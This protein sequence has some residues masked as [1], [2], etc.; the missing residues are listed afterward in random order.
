MDGL[1]AAASVIAV[2]QISGQ[3]SSLCRAYYLEVKDARNEIQRLREEV[4][5]LEDVLTKVMD[6]AD[7]PTATEVEVLKLVN[8]TEGPVQQCQAFL[9][10]L[11]AQLKK[12]QGSDTMK[13]FGLRALK[14]PFS[15]KDVKACLETIARHKATFTLAIALDD[16][17]LSRAIKADITKL[18]NDLLQ[19]Q[20]EQTTLIENGRQQSAEL[21]VDLLQLQ[22]GHDALLLDERRQKIHQWLSA[23]NPSSNHHAARKKQQATTG[24]W[25]VDDNQFAAWRDGAHSFLWLHGIRH[26]LW[27]DY[28]MAS[29][30]CS[31]IIQNVII[32][33]QSD[34]ALAIGF[35]YFDF[36]DVEK[37]KP[38]NLIRSLIT[39]LSLHSRNNPAHLETLYSKCQ[40][41][42][43]RPSVDSLMSTLKQMLGDFR[44][45]FVIIDA[46]DECKRWEELTDIV[47]SIVGWKIE[48]LHL[49]VTSRRERELMDAFD[50]LV[51][52]QIA[53]EDETVDVDIQTYV[54]HKLANDTKLGKWPAELKMEIESTLTNGAHGMFR[55]VVCQ[56]DELRKC[57]KPAV[58]RNALKSLPRTLDDTYAR[59]LCNIDEQY[60]EDAFKILQWLACS[61][62]PLTI[63]EVA[64][65]L[66]VNTEGYPRVDPDHRLRD[67][68]DVLIICSSLVTIVASTA[69]DRYGSK[70]PQKRQELRL[71]HFSVKEYLVSDRIQAGPA[72]R[73]KIT[74]IAD[75]YIAQTCLAYLL[76]FNEPNVQIP[77]YIDDPYFP[78]GEY[79]SEDA[80]YPLALYATLYWTQHAQ[81]A[82]CDQEVNAV[83]QLCM[84]LLSGRHAYLNSTRFFGA[85]WPRTFPTELDLTPSNV[86]ISSIRFA[87][88]SGL[89]VPVRQLLTENTVDINAEIA[90]HGTALYLASMNGHKAIVELLLKNG[91]DVDARGGYD[92]TALNAA[93]YGGH[94]ATI[95]L[96]LKHGA[97]V[98]AEGGTNRT[99]LCAASAGGHSTIVQLLL[100][101]GADVNAQEACRSDTA[102]LVASERGHEPIVELLLRNGADVH[103]RSGADHRTAL[104]AASRLGHQGVVQLLL[105]HQADANAEA[106]GQ[107]GIAL[108][109][110]CRNG[111]EAAVQ[112]LLNIG[113]KVLDRDRINRTTRYVT[114]ECSSEGVAQLLLEHGTDVNVLWSEYGDNALVLACRNGYEAVVEMLLNNGADMNA[115]DINDDTPLD[116]A[117]NRG[118]GGVV[119]LLLEHGAVTSRDWTEKI[120]EKYYHGLRKRRPGT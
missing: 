37:Q 4:A 82:C 16:I 88:L 45:I 22:S 115:C 50:P 44:E 11:V 90:Y 25:F 3:V 23:P 77:D 76:H 68:R 56:I 67:P 100:S 107:E 84:E 108:A 78:N 49:L 55:W 97:D 83:Q 58:L 102:L 35:F 85:S 24:S 93:S 29:G 69:Y 106:Y 110:A 99:P 41:G 65:V 59:I 28:I 14:W 73:F 2:I 32:H 26:R 12:G 17:G 64:E 109:F 31:T 5:A 30:L 43:Q 60:N 101:K 36:N 6:L 71:A 52:H 70:Q 13:R 38:E 63:E 9:T 113:A 18:H 51:S 54:R 119:Q 95:E 87:S 15:S 1:S 20:S 112:V 21:R 111:H 117:V 72:S 104:Q 79:L 42:K 10:D 47:E 40:D 48:K 39:Q 8:Q 34:Q 57:L 118:H 61:V 86:V 94:E 120:L 91:A 92:G 80:E 62:R 89:F 75:D 46:L 33:C 66:A 74:K 7:D 96:L 103:T 81:Q 98:D 116:L 53:I 19:L 114:A 105:D 27:E